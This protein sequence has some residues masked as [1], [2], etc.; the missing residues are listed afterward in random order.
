MDT[1][2]AHN[3]EPYLKKKK[4]TNQIYFQILI[5]RTENY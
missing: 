5:L 3:F 1:K 2:H 4:P